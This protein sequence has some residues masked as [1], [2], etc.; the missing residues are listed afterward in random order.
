MGNQE[1][2]VSNNLQN[3]FFKIFFKSFFR[4]V[5]DLDYHG[6][7]LIQVSLIFFNQLTKKH[8]K[9]NFFTYFQADPQL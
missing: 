9:Q 7:K 2:M 8:E 6:E 1:V 5:H 4:K 3:T